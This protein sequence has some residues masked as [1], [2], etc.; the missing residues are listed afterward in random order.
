MLPASSA[1]EGNAD[2]PDGRSPQVC[3]RGAQWKRLVPNAELRP[4]AWTHEEWAVIGQHDNTF[5]GIAATNR[6]HMKST[7]YAAQLL[8][9]IARVEAQQPSAVA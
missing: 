2:T 5:P 3:R 6:Y 8:K 4:S 7:F 9:F 1:F